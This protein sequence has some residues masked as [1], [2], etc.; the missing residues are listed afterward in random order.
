ML[1]VCA[2]DDL[3]LFIFDNLGENYSDEVSKVKIVSENPK[4]QPAFDEEYGAY[5]EISAKYYIE[6]I[7][8]VYDNLSKDLKDF[9][10]EDKQ[11]KKF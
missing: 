3:D 2:K 6:N 5:Y 1:N 11:K 7:E 8:E 9:L 4:I 10:F